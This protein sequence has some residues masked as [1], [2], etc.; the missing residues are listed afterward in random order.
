MKRELGRGEF[1]VVYEATDRELGNT[2]ALKLLSE[3]GDV[4]LERFRAEFERS[5]HVRHRNLVELYEL[6]IDDADHFYTMELVE[7]VDFVT[8]VRRYGG[9][10][11][12]ESKR[13]ATMPMAFGQPL[14][15]GGKSAFAGLTDTGYG[16][17]RRTLPQLAAGL[18]ALHD[19][20]KLHR[21]V[22]PDNVRVAPSGRVVFLDFGLAI[23]TQTDEDVAPDSGPMGTAAYMA[24]E[25]W[26]HASLGPES[27]WYA[28][29]VMLFEAITG[30]L[31]F[32][33]SAQEVFV[34][35]RTVGAPAPGLVVPGVPADLDELCLK[36][37]SSDPST[38]AGADAVAEAGSN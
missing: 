37:M 19:A 12:A 35:K 28:V 26:S 24:P 17:L 6:V 15:D 5:K 30:S 34:R 22:R 10:E 31:P 16:R 11:S 8:H 33:G 38:R 20:G 36:L 3:L 2:V 1:G 14:Q 21:D 29:G 27:D 18:S 32:S 23:D 9:S 13:R 7:G 25:Q 4:A